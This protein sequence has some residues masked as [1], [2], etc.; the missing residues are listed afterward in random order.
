[1]EIRKALLGAG[2]FWGI[3]EYFRKIEGV[4]NTKVGYS[5]GDFM[6]PSYEDVCMDIT[7]HAE[8]V[9]IEFDENI[10]SY[11]K[12]LDHFWICHNPTQLNRQGSSIGSQ[13]KSVIF[14][15]SKEQKKVAEISKNEF[16]KKLNSPSVTEI[17]EAKE[18]F[19][20][21]DYHQCY[22]QKKDE[23]S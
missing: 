20:A 4:K 18:F 19:I 13:Y 17:T 15:Y 5:G 3:E 1:M 7:G 23:L 12:V 21:E 9:L 10:I 16:Q 2:C 22:I 8:V 14:Y 6:N 11:S